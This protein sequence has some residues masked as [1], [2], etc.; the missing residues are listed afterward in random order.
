MAIAWM[1]RDDYR[2]AGFPM[3][4]VIEPDGRRAGRHAMLYAAVLVP[5]SLVP[6]LV[7]VAGNLYLTMASVLGVALF[8]LAVRFGQARNDRTARWLFLGSITY[9][10]LLWAAMIADRL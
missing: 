8:W 4:P 10:P 9:L 7:G 5:V 3:L 1:Y 6:A 2:R